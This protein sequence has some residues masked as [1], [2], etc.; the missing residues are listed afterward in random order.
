[1][2]PP[3]TSGS[4]AVRQ[5]AGIWISGSFGARP[6]QIGGD[7]IGDR[8]DIVTQMDGLGEFADEYGNTIE[9]EIDGIPLRVLSLD[10]IIV[11]KRASNRR[12]DVAVLP[13]LEETLAVLRDEDVSD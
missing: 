3:R 7:A 6:P 5:A 4:N 13:A 12:K 10:R 11:S 2:L 1:V 8:I 9:V